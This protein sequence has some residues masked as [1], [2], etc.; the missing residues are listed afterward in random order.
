MNTEPVAIARK[1]AAWASI[2][3]GIATSSPTPGYRRPSAVDRNVRYV[4][5]FEE[6]RKDPARPEKMRRLAHRPDHEC[7]GPALSDAQHRQRGDDRGEDSGE[8]DR[9]LA[10][11]PPRELVLL[12]D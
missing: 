7:H 9:H 5:A 2:S 12:P 3:R 10:D 4:G 8:E 1:Y 6:R 11:R